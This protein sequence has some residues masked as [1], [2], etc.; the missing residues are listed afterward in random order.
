VKR[1]KHY[2]VGVSLWLANQERSFSFSH[3]FENHIIQCLFLGATIFHAK[4]VQIPSEFGMK[5]V[6]LQLLKMFLL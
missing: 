4:V 6:L 5:V 2:L 1:K 3:A